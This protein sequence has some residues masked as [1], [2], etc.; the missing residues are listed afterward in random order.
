MELAVFKW[1][2]RSLQ[3]KENAAMR[4]IMPKLVYPMY[5]LLLPDRGII[6]LRDALYLT[7]ICTGI[8]TQPE[9]FRVASWTVVC[10]YQV[11][12]RMSYS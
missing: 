6:S 10:A 1:D 5:P 2:S 12:F 8:H 7:Y 11:S 3:Q 9:A 4:K